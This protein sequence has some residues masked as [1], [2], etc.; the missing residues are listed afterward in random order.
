MPPAV[1]FVHE[2]TGQPLKIHLDHTILPAEKKK[3]S[4]KVVRHGGVVAKDD[5]DVDIVVISKKADRV[6]RRLAYCASESASKR[7]VK[8][9]TLTFLEDSVNTGRCVFTEPAVKGMSGQVGGKRGSRT[10]YTTADDDHLARYIAATLPELDAG[11]RQGHKIYQKLV[12]M[13]D[14]DEEYAWTRRHSWQSWQNR[15]KKNMKRFNKAID[16]LIPV[17]NPEKELRWEADRRQNR[18]NQLEE[19]EE[20]EEDEEEDGDLGGG[21]PKQDSDTEED[22]DDAQPRP[23]SN[24]GKGRAPPSDDE[25]EPSD[26]EEGKGKGREEEKNATPPP[27]E[28]GEGGDNW[29]DT[30][31]QDFEQPRDADDP[32]GGP[33][34]SP[35][36][37]E[38]HARFAKSRTTSADSE[39]LESMEKR[40]SSSSRR[41]RSFEEA[42]NKRPRLSAESLKDSQ[43][44][45]MAR[46]PPGFRPGG[47]ASSSNGENSDND[48]ELDDVAH[49]LFSGDEDEDETQHV[50]GEPSLEHPA[51]A[52]PS[53]ASSGVM[54][55]S[56]GTT[57][58]ATAS[59][60]KTRG[61]RISSASGTN[62]Y[63]DVVEEPEERRGMKVANMDV[64]VVE[65]DD[66]DEVI[67]VEDD[68]DDA[69][70]VE[71]DEEYEEEE[72]PDVVM[73]DPEA[74]RSPSPEFSPPPPPVREEPTAQT[75]RNRRRRAEQAQKA[76]PPTRM[77]RS[78]S[79]SIEPTEFVSLPLRGTGNRKGKGRLVEPEAIEEEPEE[80]EAVS[81]Q[82]ETLAD[83]EDV[84]NIVTNED[85]FSGIS[86]VTSVAQESVDSTKTISRPVS[87]EVFEH[88]SDDEQTIARISASQ[89]LQ[90]KAPVIIKKQPRQSDAL[91][92][93]F[94]AQ[95]AA[96]REKTRPRPSLP[97][98]PALA[99]AN[100][101]LAAS[102]RGVG[103]S[104][105]KSASAHQ[106]SSTNATR[107]PKPW[108]APH[109]PTPV[110]VGQPSKMGP[111]SAASSSNETAES[112]PV[113]GTRAEAYK[114][115][116]EEEEKR[117][118]YTPPRGTR[119]AKHLQR[120]AAHAAQR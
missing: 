22:D 47:D 55:I 82:P 117:T 5:S 107:T 4:A 25:Y 49:S 58:V 28:G 36:G 38:R 100:Q 110:N 13:V 81:A 103:G 45:R 15:Y 56:D 95:K 65:S 53:A 78:R 77:T 14:V 11:G 17:I 111:V 104:P 7:K 20:E 106:R 18:G 21:K 72:V 3:W 87:P 68:E 80:P 54:T 61:G 29:E 34:K 71:D 52:G 101:K 97:P 73:D 26:Q 120:G 105:E 35:S 75:A 70:I 74:A 99:R 109:T 84:L 24:K 114:R 59:P 90:P 40:P 112:I 33:S 113:A 92:Q 44:T 1:I 63:A 43:P 116:L 94:K 98:N 50:D 31:F 115:K 6:T 19:E 88:S 12:T 86:N 66:D 27:P 51:P 16:N 64:I 39:I 30:N 119:A 85:D 23:P 8:V 2:D 89:Q 102:L 67:T 32:N 76:A 9:Q 48:Q 60:K 108:K 41:R 42:P 91:L 79:Q 96:A 10:N 46:R 37:K 93:A 57:M 118:P 62:E 83:E 69:V